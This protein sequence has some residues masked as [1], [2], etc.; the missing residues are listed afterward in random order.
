LDLVLKEIK[1]NENQNGGG[2]IPPLKPSPQNVT[3]KIYLI[4]ALGK[5]QIVFNSSMSP[6][7]ISNYNRENI[8]ISLDKYD[9]ILRKHVPQL[10]NMTWEAIEF[11][12]YMLT[13]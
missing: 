2:W 10:I 8:F 11:K 12:D 3:S 4:S 6:V 7:E 13:I 5:M 1:T 9:P